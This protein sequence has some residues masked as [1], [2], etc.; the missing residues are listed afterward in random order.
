LAEG[1]ALVLDLG[2]DPDSSAE[3]YLLE[4]PFLEPQEN[5]FHS[6]STN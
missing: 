2:F 5:Y 3:K 1:L 4:M 6:T